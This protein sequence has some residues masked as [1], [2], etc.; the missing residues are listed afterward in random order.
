MDIS[1]IPPPATRREQ[2]AVNLDFKVPRALLV[3]E[4]DLEPYQSPLNEANL[5]THTHMCPSSRE[6]KAQLILCFVNMQQTILKA[7]AELRETALTQAQELIPLEAPGDSEL[8][9][10]TI[11]DPNKTKLS[12]GHSIRNNTSASSLGVNRRRTTVL[13]NVMEAHEEGNEMWHEQSKRRRSSRFI[14]LFE[15]LSEPLK[16]LTSKSTKTTFML[17]GSK[18]LAHRRQTQHHGV[19]EDYDSGISVTSPKSKRNSIGGISLHKGR[20]VNKLIGS[21]VADDFAAFR[22]PKMVPVSPNE[23]EMRRHSTT[24][25]GYLSTAWE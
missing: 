8:I 21:E 24:D 15:K 7:E 2:H 4:E 17:P 10:D 20:S 14:N 11:C 1:T 18:A 19:N 23:R 12:L 22:Y 5:I 6:T 16:L 13:T 9:R 25:I 3:Q